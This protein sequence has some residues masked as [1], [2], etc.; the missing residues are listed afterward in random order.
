[1]PISKQKENSPDKTLKC[2][3]AKL[4]KG[5][6]MVEMM[7]ASVI[8][9]IVF[10]AA[11]AVLVSSM[12]LQKY[13]LVHH[14]LLGQVSYA[15]EYMARALRMAVKAEDSSCIA[16][17]SNFE[18]GESYVKFVNYKGDCQIFYAENGQLKIQDEEDLS[19]GVNLVSDDFEILSLRFIKAGD[20]SGDNLQ[21]RVTFYIELR[22]KNLAEK[23]RIQIQTTVSQRNLDK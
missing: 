14:Q 4:S 22:A 10:G 8:F 12:K 5:F 16:Q 13:N 21:P 6:T 19:S 1:M 3:N 15:S 11:M 23:P 2:S 7:I 20:S 17:D 18:T 9:S